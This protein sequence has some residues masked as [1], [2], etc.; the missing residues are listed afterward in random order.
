MSE[1]NDN[2]RYEIVMCMGSA[3]F[4]RGNNKSV[5][6]IRDYL[7]KNGLEASVTFR[8]CLCNN[9]CKSAPVITIN[10]QVFERVAPQ[11]VSEILEHVFKER[12]TEK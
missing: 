7:Q 11:S 9:R 3:C 4:T 10:G 5:E 12:E 1:N 6:I 8:G 2:N